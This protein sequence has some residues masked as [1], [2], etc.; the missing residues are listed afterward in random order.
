[1]QTILPES[2]PFTPE[3]RAWL[4]GFIA[5]L[6]GMERLQNATPIVAPGPA[7]EEEQLPWH[8][9]TLPLDERLKLAAGRPLEH[10]LMAAMGQMV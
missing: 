3:Q 2:A 10:Q 6:L 1:M 8:D 7:K 4:N 9:P 5:G